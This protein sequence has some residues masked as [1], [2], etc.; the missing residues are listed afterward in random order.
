MGTE[1]ACGTC[2]RANEI[3]LTTTLL[4]EWYDVDDMETLRW[5]RDELAGHPI[6]FRRGGFA[7]ASR[8]FLKDA[9]PISP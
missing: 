7:S 9:P 6:R 5:L 1:V 4:P 2:E 8:A 3:G